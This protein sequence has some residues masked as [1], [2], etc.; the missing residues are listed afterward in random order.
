MTNDKPDVTSVSNLD[1]GRYLG[2]WYE[3][4]RLPLKYEDD[5]ARDI[6]AEYSLKEDGKVR[7]DNRCI[8]EEGEPVQAVGE[9][10]PDEEHPGRL[11]VTFLPAALRWIPFTQADYWVLK[12]DDEYRRALVGTPDRKN[13]WLLARTPHVE[14]EVEDEYLAEAVRQGF[15]LAQWIRPE[16]SGSSM[17]DDQLEE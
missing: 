16:Q 8:D 7:V 13:L 1:L 9:A 6:T 17:T 5:D 10:V 4:G 2:L 15:D 14:P 12:I 3:I 11:R